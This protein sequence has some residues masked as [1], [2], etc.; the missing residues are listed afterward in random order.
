VV[1]RG[2]EAEWFEI[3]DVMGRSVAVQPGSGFGAGLPAGVYLVRA[4]AG[5][6]LQRVVKVK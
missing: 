2:R 3:R 5:A 6:E 4:Q 1:V